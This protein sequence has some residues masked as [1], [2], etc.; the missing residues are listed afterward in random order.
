M[1]L[2]VLLFFF[3]SGVLIWKYPKHENIAFGSAVIALLIAI[4][5]FLVGNNAMLLPGINY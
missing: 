3:V 4:G 5:I 1:E 2:L